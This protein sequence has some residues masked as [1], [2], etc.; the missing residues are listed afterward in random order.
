MYYYQGYY[1]TIR[2]CS[3]VYSWFSVAPLTLSTT[4]TMAWNAGSTASLPANG[5]PP[6]PTPPPS[7][8]ERL[9]PRFRTL[10]RRLSKVRRPRLLL[11]YRFV[12]C[13]M[14]VVVLAITTCGCC[15]LLFSRTGATAERSARAAAISSCATGS[16]LSKNFRTKEQRERGAELLAHGAVQNEVD[17]GVDQ[18]QDIHQV[19][20]WQKAKGIGLL[21]LK[22]KWRSVEFTVA[23]CIVHIYLLSLR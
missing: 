9:L 19:T 3:A 20:W 5:A 17:A 4:T 7:P 18:G 10:S 1:V 11:C 12:T 23:L 13:V 22:A 2:A 6:P 16:H 8:E 14:L 21:Y 15:R